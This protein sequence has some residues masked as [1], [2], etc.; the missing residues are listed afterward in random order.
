LDVGDS[1]E[2]GESSDDL[3]GGSLDVDLVRDP[4]ADYLLEGF[5][6]VEEV[7]D[8]GLV[9]GSMSLEYVNDGLELGFAGSEGAGGD[10]GEGVAGASE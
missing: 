9:W 10:S 6:L 8:L 3:G 2:L 4:E 5:L 1:V 7:E